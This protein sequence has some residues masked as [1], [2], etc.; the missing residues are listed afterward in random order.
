MSS[1]FEKIIATYLSREY[2]W[3]IA[4]GDMGVCVK[5]VLRSFITPRSAPHPEKSG[6]LANHSAAG[7]DSRLLLKLRSD[8]KCVCT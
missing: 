4:N 1:S 8:N 5:C 7:S 6:R 3:A 2:T